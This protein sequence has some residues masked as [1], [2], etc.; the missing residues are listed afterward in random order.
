[1]NDRRKSGSILNV[2]TEIAGQTNLLALNAAIEAARAGE[3]GKG[4]AVVA[5]EVRKLAEQ[6]QKSATEIH[7]IV[8][9]IQVD[10]ANSVE[11]MGHITENVLSGLDVSNEA[12]EKF[13]DILQS[14]QAHYTSDGGNFHNCRNKLLL[15]FK[16]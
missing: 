13:N 10:T 6:S 1:M 8:E 12:F 7:E 3:H 14:M 16:K 15:L 5:D 2:I 4:F 9:G 11:I